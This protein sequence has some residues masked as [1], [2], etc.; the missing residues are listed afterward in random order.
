MTKISLPF[1]PS[2]EIAFSSINCT[3]NSL[4]T[5]FIILKSFPIGCLVNMIPLSKWPT[6]Q[7]I[8]WE[9]GCLNSLW[10]S[11]EWLRQWHYLDD[12]EQFMEYESKFFILMIAQNIPSVCTS[13]R[14]VLHWKVQKWYCSAAKSFISKRRIWVRVPP[15]PSPS[16]FNFIGND[17]TIVALQ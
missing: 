8:W 11:G 17:E 2:T 9:G 6:S 3:L 13:S 7:L 14:R 16:R 4:T 12:G 5:I 10:L 1:C 15:P